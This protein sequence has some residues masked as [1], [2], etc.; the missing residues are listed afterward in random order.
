MARNSGSQSRLQ[1]RR[2]ALCAV[3]PSSRSSFL[4]LTTL[5]I[6]LIRQMRMLFKPG[7][8]RPDAEPTNHKR[9]IDDP[10][11]LCRSLNWPKPTKIRP[12]V[13]SLMLCGAAAQDPKKRKKNDRLCHRAI[14]ELRIRAVPG[15]PP[16]PALAS[17]WERSKS[18]SG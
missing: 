9:I 12:N 6:E 11:Y 17:Y 7:V 18:L 14:A 3:S 16:F 1:L 8:K 2:L 5:L 15:V 10:L 13:T 4:Y